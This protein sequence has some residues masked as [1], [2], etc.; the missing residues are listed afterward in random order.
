MASPEIRQLLAECDLEFDSYYIQ[1]DN[2][3][4]MRHRNFKWFIPMLN[5]LRSAVQE[6]RTPDYELF[7]SDPEIGIYHDVIP[8][9]VSETL[10]ARNR[11]KIERKHK[12][13]MAREAKML[14][15]LIERS[16][17]EE[18]ASAS[19]AA[20]AIST[21]TAEKPEASTGVLAANA[22]GITPPPRDFDGEASGVAILT[23]VN[24]SFQPIPDG[25]IVYTDEHG[26]TQV[27]AVTTEVFAR[28]G[29]ALTELVPVEVGDAEV[30]DNSMDVMEPVATESE[31][32]EADTTAAPLESVAETVRRIADAQQD[33]GTFGHKLMSLVK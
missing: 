20:T 16:N 12:L 7:M 1:A 22:E 8:S 9:C 24:T 31:F 5:E 10:E 4:R 18:A 23:D 25:V 14:K 11:A 13:E 2:G 29:G 19:A 27:E 28:E 3:L 30:E 15:E 32:S 6:E 33:V 17:A 21:V 26:L